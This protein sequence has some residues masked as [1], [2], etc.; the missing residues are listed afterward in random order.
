MSQTLSALIDPA[1]LETLH[2]TGL[3]AS[4]R[5]SVL[6]RL[7][8]VASAVAEAPRSYISLVTDR[9]QMFPG[10]VEHDRMDQPETRSTDLS[11]SFCQF[12]VA[13]GEPLVIEDAQSNALV[14][15][16]P[17][18][19]DGSIAAYAG[20]PLTTER[21]H[22]LGTLCV[23]D[24][25][26]REWAPEQL[27]LLSDLTVIATRELEQRIQRQ[28]DLRVRDLAG[29]LARTA[30]SASSAVTSLITR[31]EASNDTLLQRY[32]GTAR[33]RMEQFTALA[34]EVSEAATEAA[35]GSRTTETSGVADLGQTVQR[36][37][38]STLAA[39]GSS[40][41]DVQV[42][43]RPL[44]VACDPLAL[45]QSLTHLFITALHHAKHDVPVFVSVRS[46][47]DNA[48]IVVRADGAKA[49][50]GELARAVGRVHASSCAGSNNEPARVSMLRG[51]VSVEAGTVKVV[52]SPHGL[53]FTATW[54]LVEVQ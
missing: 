28:R 24:S 4:E 46:A 19:R 30:Q 41:I 39:S 36:A 44:A 40:G 1:R 13:T 32:A 7:A 42:P 12:A 5:D 15:D 9:G 52:S 50:A 43:A 45:E 29:N 20:I 49:P 38:R 23:A 47:D 21:G 22:V 25:H 54:P 35:Q 8:R 27:Q 10:M 17:G 53:S 14:R 18:N 34:R 11:G 6:D 3:L 33:T 31:A 48:T 26:S 2:G 51:G 37:V 16:L